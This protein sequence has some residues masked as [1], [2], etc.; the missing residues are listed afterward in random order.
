MKLIEMWGAR[1]LHRVEEKPSRKYR[2]GSKYD[3]EFDVFVESTDDLV[4]VAVSGREA[5]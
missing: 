4:T 1:D 2:K 3:P 5:N